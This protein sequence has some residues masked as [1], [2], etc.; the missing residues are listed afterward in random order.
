M[1]K[2]L[3]VLRSLVFWVIFAITTMVYGGLSWLLHLFPKQYRHPMIISWARLNVYALKW[4]CGVDF[5]LEGYENIPKEAS[6]VLANHQSTW[7]TLALA[8]L[9]PQQT[10]VIK[11]ELLNIPFFGWG[12][13]IVNPIAVDRSAGMSAVEQ[14][15]R[16]GTQ[17]L[18]EGWWIVVFPEGTR[19]NPGEKKRYKT[20]GSRLAAAS[21]VPVVPV[22]HNAGL[23][24]PRHQ[25]IKTPGL[26]TVRFGDAMETKGK[27]AEEINAAAE[28]WIRANVDELMK[29]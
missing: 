5:K 10:W 12:V 17:R 3:L 23:R 29:L 25:F 1:N 20:G 28:V 2:V 27:T 19:V 18:A 24:W 15:V 22:A 4:I 13:R 16:K 8:F 11:R 26:I 6:I 7:E 21:G 9:V 14:V